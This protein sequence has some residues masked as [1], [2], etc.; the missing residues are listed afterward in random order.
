MRHFLVVRGELASRLRNADDGRG[1]H[2]EVGDAS[3][4]R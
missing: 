1:A 3:V 2:P 4:L